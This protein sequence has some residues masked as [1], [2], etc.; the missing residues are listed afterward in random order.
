MHGVKV[1]MIPA[2]DRLTMRQMSGVILIDCIEKCNRLKLTN[3]N[4]YAVELA[5]MLKARGV[6]VNDPHVLLAVLMDD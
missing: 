6:R 1:K 5:R 4:V 2:A 3:K